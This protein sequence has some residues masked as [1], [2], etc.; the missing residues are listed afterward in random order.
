MPGTP[1]LPSMRKWGSPR[2]RLRSCAGSRERGSRTI[3]SFATTPS[4][5]HC[6]VSQNFCDKCAHCGASGKIIARNLAEVA[7][8]EAAEGKRQLQLQGEFR[9][10]TTR[11]RQYQHSE[12]NILWCACCFCLTLFP[13]PGNTARPDSGM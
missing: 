7:R 4:S 8:S 5:L 9:I 10:E 6:G 13:Q 1:S 3:H 12:P 11:Y 2:W